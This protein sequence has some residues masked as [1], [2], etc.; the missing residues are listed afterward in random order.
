MDR[1]FARLRPESPPIDPG[2]SAVPSDGMCLNVFL[3]V[4]PPTQR[5]SVLAGQIANDSRWADVGA[6]GA[7]RRER[8]MGR[9]MLPSRQLLLFESPDD[10]A[11]AVAREQLGL[12][13]PDVSGPR[14]FSETYTRSGS[15][16]A[17][18][19]WDVHFVY[20]VPGPAVP[21]ESTLWQRLEYIEVAG[22]P[23][24]DFAR[25]HGDVLELAGLPPAP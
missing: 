19:H 5:S 10:A 22:T 18:P 16:A 13:P 3:L 20:S 11:R 14:V 8:V 21:P 2:Y 17:D 24:H 9:W 23:R 15:T 25:G 12:E 4:H 6:L 1:R 7:D